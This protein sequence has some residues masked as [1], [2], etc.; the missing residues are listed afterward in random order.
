MARRLTDNLTSRYYE[1]YNHLTSKQ[2]RKRIIA[3]VESFDDIFFWRTV[4]SD[5]EDD[6]IYFEIM[7]P[8]RKKLVRGKK[9]VLKNTFY[10]SFS[11]NIFFKKLFI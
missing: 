2:A 10:L 7:L 11:P 5:F 9:S 4:L 8:S 6:N 3:Y 1:A